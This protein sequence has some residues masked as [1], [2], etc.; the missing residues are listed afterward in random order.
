MARANPSVI[1]L[2]INLTTQMI[3]GAEWQKEDWIMNGKECGRKHQRLPI[4]YNW[5]ND[6]M[7]LRN[8][9]ET[10]AIFFV[11]KH[12]LYSPPKFLFP[13]TK[14]TTNHFLFSTPTS[15]QTHSL[16]LPKWIHCCWA[17]RVTLTVKLGTNNVI[18]LLPD[19]MH[20]TPTLV[21]TWY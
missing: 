19:F 18:S 17:P 9:A 21:N 5:N 7:G 15:I 16:F 8:F 6:C 20:L 12:K 2:T 10:S 4:K 3:Y 13:T 1:W 14:I 11:I